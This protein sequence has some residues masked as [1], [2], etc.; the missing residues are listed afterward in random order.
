MPARPVSLAAPIALIGAA[1]ILPPLWPS[2]VTAS[3]DGVDWSVAAD[4]DGCRSCHL[5]PSD[6][7]DVAALSINGLPKQPR[8]GVRYELTVTLEHPALRNAGFLLAVE[9]EGGPAG[10][11][12]P[13]DQRTETSGA[14]ARS[15]W[16]GSFPGGPGRASWELVWTAPQP[17]AGPI[18]FSLWANAGND[19]LSPLGDHPAHRSWQIAAVR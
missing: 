16:E 6:A 17:T 3:P 13:A 7:P 10:T 8:S 1:V 18:V 14:S 11:L 15:T 4:A 12:A 19:D 2:R 5:G 9:S